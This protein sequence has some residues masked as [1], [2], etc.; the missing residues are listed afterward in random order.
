LLAVHPEPAKRRPQES[1]ELAERAATD[2]RA[3]P[4]QLAEGKATAY[5]AAGRL[6]DAAKELEQ[7][8]GL[9]AAAERGERADALDPRRRSA[10]AAELS[11]RLQEIRAAL[12]PRGGAK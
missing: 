12:E 7:A 10:L 8:L 4:L 9:L 1:V 6:P 3:D 2:P 5:A 11:R